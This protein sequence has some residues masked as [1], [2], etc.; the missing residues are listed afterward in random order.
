MTRYAI[1]QDTD[2]LTIRV[3][4]T[5]VD[6]DRLLAEI[7]DCREGRCDCP[8]DEYD[9][10]ES[11]SVENDGADDITMRLVPKPGQWFDESEID[12]CLQHTLAKTERDQSGSQIEP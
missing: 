12:A 9:K 5:G 11:L 6:K 10:V 2:G 7:Q 8:T 1:D 4:D 3:T